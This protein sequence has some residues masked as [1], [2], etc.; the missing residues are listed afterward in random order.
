MSSD[1]V[2]RQLDEAQALRSFGVVVHGGDG[3]ITTCNEAAQEILG[4][5]LAQL[6]ACSVGTPWQSIYP[7]GTSFPVESHPAIET[8][9][10]GE[11]CQGVIMGYYRPQGELIWLAIETQPLINP[12]ADSPCAVIS[13]FQEVPAPKNTSLTTSPTSDSVDIPS[14]VSALQTIL[15]KTLDIIF[16]KD[17]HGRYSAISEAGADFLGMTVSEVIGKTD[18]DLFSSDVFYNIQQIDAQVM[19]TGESVTFEEQI[20]YASQ[21]K[22]LMT[23]K[24]PWRDQHGQLLGTMGICRDVTELNQAKHEEHQSRLRLAKVLD[25]LHSFV[26]L[27]TPEGILIEV[28]QLA[29]DAANLTADEV[30]GKRLPEAY[31]WSYSSAVQAQLWE[32]IHRAAA[33]EPVRYDVLVRLGE[34]HFITID[35]SLGPLF[36]EAGEVEYLVP[37]GLDIT[38]R[39]ETEKTLRQNQAVIQSQLSEIESIYQTA[40][41]G[42]A[43]LDTEL[44]FV[45]INQK[46]AEINGLSIDDHLGRSVRELLP[47]LADE[48]EPQLRQVLQ[49]GEPALNVE[50][51]GETPARPGIHRT[52]LESWYPQLGQDTQPVGI[53]IVCQEVTEQKRLREELRASNKHLK[54]ALAGGSVCTWRWNIQTHQVTGNELF[55]NRFNLD[56]AICATT[57]YPIDALLEVIYEA[58]RPSVQ[59]ALERALATQTSFTAEY[60]LLHLSPQ[61]EPSEYW[62][63]SRGQLDYG[64]SEQPLA[65]VGTLSDITDLKQIETALRE[66]ETRFRLMTELLPQIFWTATPTGDLDYYSPQWQAYIGVSAD[67]TTGWAWRD[68]IHPDDYPEMVRLWQQAV[69]QGS[70]YECE[71]RLRRFDG[72]YRWF[73]SRSLPER[74]ASGEIVKWYGTAIDIHAQKQVSKELEQA[75]SREKSALAESNRA[76]RIKDEFLAVLSHELRSPLNPILGWARLL[77]MRKMSEEKTAHALETIERNAQLQTQLIDDLLDVAKILRGKLKFDPEPVALDAVILSACDT[78]KTTAAAKSIALNL[79]IIEPAMVLGDSTRLQ[80]IVWNLLSNAVKFTSNQGKVNVQLSQLEGFAKI[81]VSDTGKGIKADFL[82]HLFES[83]RQEDATITRSY[84]GLGLGLSIVSYLVDMHGGT[85]TAESPGEGLGSTFTV[86][87]PLI[88]EA[89]NIQATIEPE[90]EVDLTGVQ[91]LCVDDDDDSREIIMALLSAYGATVKTATCAAEAMSLLETYD[92]DMLV[93]DIG[94]PEID[95]YQLLDQIRALPSGRHRKTPAIALTAYARDED[96]EAAL[97]KGFQAH[98]TKPIDINEVV[99]VIAILVRT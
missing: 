83:F 68:F 70:F 1:D 13:T 5:T 79:D 57:G 29:L 4:L 21:T 34:E 71:H 27:L 85:I 82:P 81:A 16:F 39:Q 42:M 98:A 96:R 14:V 32:A 90:I 10:T 99:N 84:G 3:S 77:Q 38:Y 72:E 30:I 54:A 89:D 74:L 19:A 28:N 24:S 18:R 41:V 67:S 48:A 62:M 49:T 2:E 58:D 20:V 17:V 63:L 25:S 45:R 92:P 61:D 65:Y 95:G 9:R 93:L 97:S 87:L 69:E 31:W 91:F 64:E 73:L 33:G 36:N 44:R 53:N 88:A 6:Q 52:W 22:T 47:D 66:S 94:M 43:V 75:L 40:P 55:A 46:L 76:N 80:Q 86:T 37:S 60:R 12:G 56:P 59:Q 7:D 35:F 15:Q 78:V 51:S 11:A 8:L 23:T 50:I 26:G